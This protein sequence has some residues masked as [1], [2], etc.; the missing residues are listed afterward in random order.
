MNWAGMVIIIWLAMEVGASVMVNGK[1]KT[2][3]HSFLTTLTWTLII[4]WL[5]FKAGAFG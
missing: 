5:M 2:G 3:K 4:A 1:P